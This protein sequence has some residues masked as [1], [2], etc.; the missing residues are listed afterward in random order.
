MKE[1]SLMLLIILYT[2]QCLNVIGYIVLRNRVPT[3]SAK[4][5]RSCC[6]AGLIIGTFACLPLVDVIPLVSFSSFSLGG[7]YYLMFVRFRIGAEE[8]T[9]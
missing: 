8:N 2:F 4:V 7:S 9:R 3:V 1:E 6:I 5:F